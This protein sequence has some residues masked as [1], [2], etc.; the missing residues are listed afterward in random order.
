MT[1]YADPF[2]RFVLG[3]VPFYYVLKLGLYLALA[4]PNIDLAMRLYLK[5]IKPKT[6]KI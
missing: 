4:H 5:F 6:T 1:T 2:I 3:F